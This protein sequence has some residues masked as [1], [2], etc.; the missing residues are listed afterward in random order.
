MSP[1]G[2]KNDNRGRANSVASTT[3]PL[4]RS[5]SSSFP[6][7]SSMLGRAPPFSASTSSASRPTSTRSSSSSFGRT[8]SNSLSASSSA[9][10]CAA[11]SCHG[12]ELVDESLADARRRSN[13][14]MDVLHRL[15][16]SAASRPGSSR[17]ALWPTG[18]AVKVMC[19]LMEGGLDMSEDQ[20][21]DV[22]IAIF[23]RYD[24][25]AETCEVRL[26]D[27]STRI[28]SARRVARSGVRFGRG[29]AS[30]RRGSSKDSGGPGPKSAATV[31]H[32]ALGHH[33]CNSAISPQSPFRS[34]A[35]RERVDGRVTDV[36]RTHHL[37]LEPQIYGL[38]SI[39][40]QSLPGDQ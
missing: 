4:S 24:E 6:S 3:T 34:C 12:D 25:L 37:E 11:P 22:L 26:D 31:I 13:M 18:C 28:V 30:G 40:R 35:T 33:Q 7:Q 38:S 36:E 1:I 9:W 19:E 14:S 10:S 29:A 39:Q 27:G 2:G 23:V 32:H 16:G 15:Q 5:S 8:T 17:C 21:Q 20:T